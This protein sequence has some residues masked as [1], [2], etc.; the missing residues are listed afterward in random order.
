VA[1]SRVLIIHIS[2]NIDAVIVVVAARTGA[3]TRVISLG[4]NGIT[5]GILITEKGFLLSHI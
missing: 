2:G 1:V 5:K 4:N 3:V